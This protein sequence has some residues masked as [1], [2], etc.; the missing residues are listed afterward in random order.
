MGRN[1]RVTL[2]CAS[3]DLPSEWTTPA[4]FANVQLLR[5]LAQQ[6]AAGDTPDSA[7]RKQ[8]RLLPPLSQLGHPLIHAFEDQ[9]ASADDKGTLRE[10]ISAVNDR[11]WFK[12]TYS[13][14]WRGAAV[15]LEQDGVE[16]AWLGAAGYHRKGSPEDFYEVFARRCRT[17]SDSF[18]PATEDFKVRAVEVKVARHDAWKLQLHLTTLALLAVALNSPEKTCSVTVLSPD[19]TDLLT[20]SMIVVHTDVAGNTAHE[21]VVDLVPAS[22]ERPTLCQ[23]ASVVVK[24][25]ID[26]QF[27]TW[28]SAPLRGN[29]ESHWTVLTEDSMA[30]AHAAAESG[31]LTAESRPGEVRLGTIAHY[32]RRDGITYAS[33]SGEAVQAMCGHWFVPTADHEEKPRC[34]TCQ[35]QYAST[36]A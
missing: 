25:A 6:A 34:V 13:S 22:W 11:Q 23:Q 3:E 17:G 1:R 19:S 2:R 15:L 12:Q 7:V 29:A 4:D 27:E 30:A 5:K 28:T 31:A 14:R 8:L 36:P 16:T 24:T 21:L 33:V 32:T 26:P 20:L 18:L 35:E 9:F 10:T